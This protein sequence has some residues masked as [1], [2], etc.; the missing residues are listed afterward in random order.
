MIIPTYN[1]LEDYLKPCI[2]KKY[3]KN[4]KLIIGPKGDDVQGYICINKDDPASYFEVD[5]FNIENFFDENSI[6]ELI[7]SDL[8]ININ[9]YNSVELFTKLYKV[10]QYNGKII[11]KYPCIVQLFNNENQLQNFNEKQVIRL[12]D[13]LKSIGFVIEQ[14]N[15]SY[16]NDDFTIIITKSNI[17]SKTI[18]PLKNQDEF[19]YIE[20][21]EINRYGVKEEE[22]RNKIV[23][24]IG[25][26][27]GFFSILC[28]QY[29]AKKIL[30]FEPNPKSFE[31]LKEN[32]AKLNN[33]EIFNLAVSNNKKSVE[34]NYNGGNSTVYYNTQNA[35]NTKISIFYHIITMNDYQNIFNEFIAS[36]KNSGL[37]NVANKI[38]L[39]IL[40]KEEL[41]NI[42]KKAEII[43]KSQNILEYEFP[44]LQSLW[45]YCNNYSE[46]E[47][48]LYCHS[49]SASKTQDHYEKE[50]SMLHK[51]KMINFCINNYLDRIEELNNGANTCGYNFELFPY[52]HYSG[53][54]WWTKKS[55]INKL[56]YPSLDIIKHFPYFK[57]EAH[58]LYERYSCEMWLLNCFLEKDKQE[59]F[60]S[61]CI[62]I[63]E[64]ISK[65]KDAKNLILK[66]DIEG[67]EYDILLNTSKDLL[68]LF[69]TIYIEIHDNIKN[70]KY[71]SKILIEYLNKNGFIVV[72]EGPPMVEFFKDG[73]F[74]E[75]PVYTY[76][77]K[78]GNKI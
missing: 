6:R 13:Y 34:M 18:I 61:Q 4:I 55:Y 70:N 67:S 22:I 26:Y 75:M 45:K 51:N 65:I 54:F 24:D 32:T 1:R 7:L 5:I 47:Y 68:N 37:Y 10:L 43:Y 16:I 27:L 44:T 63:K 59:S 66:M 50:S 60:I 58:C 33:I 42:P 9:V 72:H 21:F 46:E 3:N 77:F 41:L 74:K 62:S 52:P 78:N 56:S 38:Y 17:P 69:E 40:G 29:S 25:G 49:K 39:S 28:N 57:P 15:K 23:I 8:T 14:N 11:I 20:I 12:Y 53:N 31:I 30:C 19:V 2:E 76:K 36:I 48:I 64:I 35:K 73:S 71:N